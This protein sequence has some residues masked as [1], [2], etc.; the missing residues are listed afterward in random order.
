MAAASQS[1][2]SEGQSA[3]DVCHSPGTVCPG[4]CRAVVL[5]LAQGSPFCSSGVPVACFVGL[6]K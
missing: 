2:W 3:P 5:Q 1:C 4:Q 6:W